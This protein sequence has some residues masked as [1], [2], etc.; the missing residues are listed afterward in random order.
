LNPSVKRKVTWGLIQSALALSLM[1]ASADALGM[2]Q[3]ASIAAAF[4][5]AFVMIFGMIS[6]VK[7][8]RKDVRGE[9]MVEGAVEETTAT[10]TVINTDGA[11]FEG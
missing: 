11:Q 5:F 2:L 6:L 9:P 7:A 8:L 10:E 4:P 1:L 3:T